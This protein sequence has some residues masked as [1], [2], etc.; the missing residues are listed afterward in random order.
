MFEKITMKQMKNPSFCSDFSF[1]LLAS[2]LHNS[3]QI[4]PELLPY[5]FNPIN[6]RILSETLPFPGN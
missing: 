5:V 6:S 3:K 4:Y 1:Y 2:L